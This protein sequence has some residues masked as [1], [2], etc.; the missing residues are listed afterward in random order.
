M[1]FNVPEIQKKRHLK[2]RENLQRL[3]KNSIPVTHLLLHYDSHETWE[4]KK[5]SLALQIY[6]DSSFLWSKKWDS[7]SSP[8]HQTLH[9]NVKV[10]TIVDLVCHL[11]LAISFNCCCSHFFLGDWSFPFQ[12]VHS[13]ITFSSTLLFYELKKL[14]STISRDGLDPLLVVWA[15]TLWYLVTK[16]RRG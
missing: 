3:I 16:L 12:G 8:V 7:Y 6:F 9:Y 10:M 14:Q 15:Q 2:E 11:W 4:A 1:P 13:Y 5:S